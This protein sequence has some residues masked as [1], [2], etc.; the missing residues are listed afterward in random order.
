MK[1]SSGVLWLISYINVHVSDISKAAEGEGWG[2]GDH[3]ISSQW[4][5]VP[6][7]Y[8]DLKFEAQ[9]HT[10]LPYCSFCS[11]LE[12]RLKKNNLEGTSHSRTFFFNQQTLF[13]PNHGK[14]GEWHI[15]FMVWLHTLIWMWNDA[16][17]MRWRCWLVVEV[18]FYSQLIK[19]QTWS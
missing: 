11:T 15:F 3:V 13:F 4:D 2:E 8:W 9:V 14:F 7:A 12:S 19:D 6:G 10:L 18:L 17:K 1:C 16:M 5:S